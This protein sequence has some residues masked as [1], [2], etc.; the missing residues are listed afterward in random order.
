LIGLEANH[1]FAGGDQNIRIELPVEILFRGI[2]GTY[3][4]QHGL[5]FSLLQSD[6][7]T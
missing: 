6:V 2:P 1:P 7:L 5:T 4:D 3:I